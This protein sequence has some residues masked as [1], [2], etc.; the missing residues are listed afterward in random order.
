LVCHGIWGVRFVQDV[1]NLEDDELK[2]GAR[3][4]KGSGEED[5]RPFRLDVVV[6]EKPG[7]E[8]KPRKSEV[9]AQCYDYDR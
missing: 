2:H 9:Q 8:E 1:Q 6:L 4:G 7:G 5:H 3:D